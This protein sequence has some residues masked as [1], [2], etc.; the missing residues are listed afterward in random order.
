MPGAEGV[1][2]LENRCFYL[3]CNG[4]TSQGLEQKDAANSVVVLRDHSAG[5]ERGRGREWKRGEGSEALWPRSGG[6]MTVTWAG[7][8]QWPW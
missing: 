2:P 5:K 4:E 3:E 1:Q 8:W 6:E 7:W